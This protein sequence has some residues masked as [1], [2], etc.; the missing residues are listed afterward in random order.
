MKFEVDT[1]QLARTVSK[2]TTVLQEIEDD[3]KK[4]YLDLEALDAMWAGE[5]HD[6]F[7]AQYTIDD[8]FMRDL[9]DAIGGMIGDV[10]EA[11]QEYD[12]CEEEVKQLASSIRI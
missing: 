3:K 6:A 12:L 10:S 11:R 5:A 7:K 8:Q 9:L 2:L 1:S 4:M